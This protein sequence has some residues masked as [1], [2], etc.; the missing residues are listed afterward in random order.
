[1]NKNKYFEYNIHTSNSDVPDR[2]YTQIISIDPAKKNF[3]IRIEKRYSTCVVTHYFK[4]LDLSVD[5][6]IE[7]SFD[8]LTNILNEIRDDILDSDLIF[9]EKQLPNNYL[10]VRIAQHALSYFLIVLKNNERR[11]RVFEVNSKTKN[12]VINPPKGTKAK[13]IKKL[14]VVKAKEILD[15]R[16]DEVA[17]D[18]LVKNKRKQDDLCDTIC[19]IEAMLCELNISDNL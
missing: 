3:T 9:I 12:L 13:E 2:D 14:S 16:Q 7:S 4:R 10:A 6:Y 18:I 17:L 11:T 19:Q 15:K 1:M 8:V 5:G